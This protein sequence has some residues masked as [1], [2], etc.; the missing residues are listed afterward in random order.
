MS[1]VSGKTFDA[2]LLRRV[3]NYV[4]PY[5]TIFYGTSFCAILIAFL[6][7]TR[8][9]LIQ[10]AFDNFIINPD[11]KKLLH[12]TL[13]LVCLLFVESVLQYFY[14]YWS[15]FLG[16]SVI[17][18]LRQQV[19]DKIIHFKQQYFDKNPIGALVTRVVSDIETISDIFSQGL[20]VIIADILKLIIVIVVM[21]V[22]DWRLTLFSLASIPL[23]LVATYWFKRSIKSAFQDVRKQVSALNTF[24]QEH[25]VGMY[26]VQLFNREDIEFEKFK[27][28]NDA[29]KKAHIKSIWYYSVF[30]PIVEILSAI[31]IGLLIWW[32]GI[33]AATSHEVTLGELIAFILYIH[34]LFRPIRQLAD[35]FNV[36]QMGMVA[37]ERVFKV[38][39]TDDSISN[40][41]TE[42]LD[43]CKGDIEFKNVW[44]AYNDEDWVLKDVSFK[45]KAGETLALVGATGAGKSSIIN[46]LTRNYEI[47]KGA[48]FIDGVNYLDYDLNSL[49]KNVAVVLQDVFLFSDTIFNNI[50]LGREITKEQVATYAKEIEIEE[51]IESLPQSYDYNVRE[52]G[53]MLS[54]GQRQLLSFLRAYVDKPKILVLDEATSSIDSESEYLIQRS[55][56]KLTKGR[57]SVVIAHRLATVQ[58]ADKIILL[59]NGEIK[60]EGSHSELLSIKGKYKL[61][62]DLQFEN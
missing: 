59:E 39:D 24:V 35:R 57:T 2:P 18:D 28:I 33:Q 7:P 34:M 27:S 8:P 58:N 62:F 49:R 6:S 46:L 17:R 53:G 55:S 31:S 56:E 42:S 51:F 4:G 54:L 19:Y 16:Q 22:T 10:Y 60:E 20:L 3:L 29:H 25:I 14:T 1:R 52:R 40:L 21:F 44:F 48:I 41:G 36:L 9:L 37:S 43:K 50:T 32:G 11:E 45:I 15:N 38:L 5:M 12:I 26:I 30:F 61:L 13:L 23:L 47:N